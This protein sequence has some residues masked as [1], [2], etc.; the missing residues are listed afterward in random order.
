MSLVQSA[1]LNGHDPLG[2]PQR[3]AYA[4]ADLP[5]QPHRRVA[6]ASL[7]TIRLTPLSQLSRVR[8]EFVVQGACPAAY[9][10]ANAA[11]LVATPLPGC[12][13]C[14]SLCDVSNT[15]TAYSQFFVTSF[16]A[17]VNL[18]LTLPRIVVV[19]SHSVLQ[20]SCPGPRAN[21]RKFGRCDLRCLADPRAC[22][23]CSALF[24]LP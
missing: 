20:L 17:D 19:H 13:M 15:R 14:A 1:K 4:A 10:S 3:R 24:S 8:S 16:C 9:L 7:A 11:A 21:E 22:T 12:P 23:L 18:A 6:A 2:L 5:E